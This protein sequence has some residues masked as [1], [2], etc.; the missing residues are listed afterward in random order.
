MATANT[1][2]CFEEFIGQKV[3]GCLFGAMP[4]NRSD[5]GDGCKTL[6]FEDGRGLTI[7]STGSYWVESASEVK[8]AVVREAC[9]LKETKRQIKGV[10]DL[11][12]ALND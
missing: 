6:V 3:I 4:W 2:A 11:A 8:A 12:G 7:S 5:M 9:R 10:L 1:H